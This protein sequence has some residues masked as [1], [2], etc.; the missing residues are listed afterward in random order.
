MKKAYF[1]IGDAY[2]WRY[3][4]HRIIRLLNSMEDVDVYTATTGEK[5]YY[6]ASDMC[7]E[8][9]DYVPVDVGYKHQSIVSTFVYSKCE[10]V[11]R[12]R[13]TQGYD[14]I[15]ILKVDAVNGEQILSDKISE[16]SL[17]KRSAYF[18]ELFDSKV[19]DFSDSFDVNVPDRSRVFLIP[20]II[21][22][23]PDKSH[24]SPFARLEQ[25][26]RQ[27][28]SIRANVPNAVVLLLEMG[29][30][31]LGEIAELTPFVDKL[32]FFS[33]FPG[34]PEHIYYPNKNMGEVYVIELV[35][36]ALLTKSFSY[37]FKFG[38]RYW[39]PHGFQIEGIEGSKP[40]FKFVPKGANYSERVDFVESVLYSVPRQYLP[41]Y[42]EII[43]Q[44][45][46]IL[47]K[48]WSSNEELLNALFTERGCISY[49][50][51]I[52]VLGY[53]ATTGI[54]NVI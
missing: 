46:A 24:F 12:E 20:S 33:K 16:L 23:P 11:C 4:R 25:T 9:V 54:L 15:E 49:V 5:I 38:G 29:D 50:P 17:E 26:V 51:S 14:T 43:Q 48:S 7:N 8:L 34:A 2:W 22:V 40:A 21:H 41:M 31:S 28:K 3:T 37:L 52:G 32:C 27:V 30:L 13:C 36:P 18:T 44:M 42:T 39:M 47:S 53:G 6:S 1:L 10:S 45:Y 35:L 19:C